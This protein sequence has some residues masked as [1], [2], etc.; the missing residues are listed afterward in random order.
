MANEEYDEHE[1]KTTSEKIA[2]IYDRQKFIASSVESMK[3]D[4]VNHVEQDHKNF[5]DLQKFNSKLIGM[6]AVLVL[7]IPLLTAAIIKIFQK[8]HPLDRYVNEIKEV[9]RK[10]NKINLQDLENEKLR[11]ELAK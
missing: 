1:P 9:S 10:I 6:G 5:G 7:L 4:L 11:K 3:K 2:V 8:D